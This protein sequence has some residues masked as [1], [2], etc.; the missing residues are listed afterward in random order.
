MFQV[1]IALLS[2]GLREVYH[3]LG[4]RYLVLECE[5]CDR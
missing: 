5:K 1:H 2:L 4:I 3:C